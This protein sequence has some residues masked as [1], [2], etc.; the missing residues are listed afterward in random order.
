MEPMTVSMEQHFDWGSLLRFTFPSIL[1][2]IFTSLY[3]IVDGLFVSNFAGKTAFAAVNLIM[4]PIIILST[5]GYMFGTGG[6]ALVA[7]TRGEGDDAR[8]NRYFSLVVYAGFVA[9]LVF[10]AVG[11]LLMEPIA[12]AL[13]ASPEMAPICA[14]YGRLIMLSLPFYILQY[15][16]QSFFIT[17][18]KPK[19]GLAVILIAGITNMV[20]DAVLVGL[21]N[22]G[23]VGAALATV[24]SE[25]LGGGLPLIYFFRKNQ[26]FLRLGRTRFEPRPLGKMCVNGMSEMMTGIAMSVVSMLYNF[27]LMAMAGEDGVAVYGIIMYVTMVFAAIFMGYDM[28]CAPLMSFQYGAKNRREMRSLLRKSLA[29]TAVCGVAM[30]ALG[31]LFAGAIAGI[32]VSYDAELRS[33]AE[34]GFKLYALAYLLMGFSMYGSSFFTALNNGVVSAIISFLRTLVFE[35][36]SVLLLPLVLGVNGVWLSAG[37]AEVAALIITVTFMWLLGPHYGYRDRLRKAA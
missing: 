26:S 15:I 6:S 31:Q 18:G 23:V 20:L 5:A 16:F 36:A 34:H 30:F 9:G 37:V 2:V 14:L 32:F 17:A 27:Q 3:G 35:V 33:F 10:A 25:V 19:M 7:K 21:L 29:F 4:P 8:A 1:M 11:A 12:Y 13:G 28:G 24:T 22:M